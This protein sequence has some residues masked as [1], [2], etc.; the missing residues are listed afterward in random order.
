MSVYPQSLPVFTR[1]LTNLSGWLEQAQSYAE[2]R[3]F[4]V[5][6]LASSRLAPDQFPL[7]RQVQAAC[8]GAKLAVARLTGKDAPSH[9][10][11]ETTV[12]ELKARIESTLGFLAEFGEADF[13]GSATRK[14]HLPFLKEQHMVGADYVH[15]FALPNFM[16]HATH[17]YAILRHNGVPLG[18][19]TFL[20][21][22]TLHP[23]E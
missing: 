8:D 17:A 14:V 13:E 18:K 16:F 12:A 11:E 1:I 6:T 15:Q 9:P 21:Q 10:D 22:V 19:R 3:G 5:D 2:E 20:G 23:D 4:E 7:T